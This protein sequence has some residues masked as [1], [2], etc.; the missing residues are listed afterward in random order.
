MD[1]GSY[2]DP[3]SRMLVIRIH[4]TAVLPAKLIKLFTLQSPGSCRDFVPQRRKPDSQKALV[5]IPECDCFSVL[6]LGLGQLVW[7]SDFFL[8]P[9]REGRLW[10]EELSV[11]TQVKAQLHTESP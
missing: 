11:G 2:N 7:I 1:S 6:V 5:S 10:S 3:K 4:V 8:K 9:L